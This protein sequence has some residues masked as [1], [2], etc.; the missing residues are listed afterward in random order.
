MHTKRQ[1]SLLKPKAANS[2]GL[3]AFGL[4]YQQIDIGYVL[5]YTKALRAKYFCGVKH[6]L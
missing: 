2:C 4:F 5:F 3:V 6:V 1:V